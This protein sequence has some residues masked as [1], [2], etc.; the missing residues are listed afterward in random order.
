[1]TEIKSKQEI[2]EA[3][4]RE[5]FHDIHVTQGSDSKIFSRLCGLLSEEYLKL[6]KGFFKDKICL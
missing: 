5:V 3:K 1:M 2:L 6:K 4:T